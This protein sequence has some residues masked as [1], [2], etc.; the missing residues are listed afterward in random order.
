[1]NYYI[2][3]ANCLSGGIGLNGNIPW[4]CKSDLKL[5]SK[6]T[7]GAS[8]NVIIMGRKTWESLPKSPLPNRTN[9]ILSKTLTLKPLPPNTHIFDNIIDIKTFCKENNYDDVWIIGGEQIY[10]LF[11][12]DDDLNGLYLTEICEE[13]KCD[14]FF[15][16]IPSH[17]N[18]IKCEEWQDEYSKI[19]CKLNTYLRS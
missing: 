12:N 17:F 9:I 16:E 11:I 4:Q 3:A 13:F 18:C 8:N 5:F 1:M 19:N 2:I 6:L 7:K 15:P 14:T 10:N